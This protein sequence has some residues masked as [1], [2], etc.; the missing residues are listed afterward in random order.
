MACSP[1]VCTLLSALFL[2][3]HSRRGEKRA[4]RGPR[5]EEPRGV[6]GS[7]GGGHAPL[8]NLPQACAGKAGARTKE[9][10][11]C[12]TENVGGR[13]TAEGEASNSITLASEREPMRRVSPRC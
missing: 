8:P 5:E 12:P 1:R 7:L 11:P 6:C 3:A 9:R 10:S 4:D 13:A 2:D